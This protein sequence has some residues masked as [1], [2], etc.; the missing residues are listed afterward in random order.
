M[1]ANA[2]VTKRDGEQFASV[3][4]GSLPKGIYVVKVIV[5]GND[6]YSM[7]FNVK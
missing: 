3:N 5:D 4:V 1:K 2:T 6:E 7:K